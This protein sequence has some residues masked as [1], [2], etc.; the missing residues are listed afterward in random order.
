MSYCRS[1]LLV[2]FSLGF[3]FSL[4]FAQAS[5]D[6][7]SNAQLASPEIEQKVDTLLKRMT[8]DEKIGQLIQYSATEAHPAKLSGPSTAALNVNPPVPGGIDSYALAQ[9][10]ELG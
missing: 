1:T 7:A 10:G 9:K 2:G 4:A 3:V 5:H 6:A 8:F